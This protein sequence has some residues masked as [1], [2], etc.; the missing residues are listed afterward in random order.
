VGEFLKAL[1]DTEKFNEYINFQN[2]VSKV[3]EIEL[4]IEDFN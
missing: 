3:Y 1:K 2:V 4:V